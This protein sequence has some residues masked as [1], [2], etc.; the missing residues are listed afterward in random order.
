V[1]YDADGQVMGVTIINA[2][3]LLERDGHVTVTLPHEVRVEARE[4]AWALA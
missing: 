4:L 1:R 2:R 3:L